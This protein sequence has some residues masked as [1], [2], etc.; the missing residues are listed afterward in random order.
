MVDPLV[1]VMALARV[2]GAVAAPVWA[3]DPWGLYLAPS[4]TASL[5]AVA[6]GVCWLRM[7]GRPPRQLLAGDVVLL[8]TGAGH[9]LAGD[10]DGPVEPFDRVAKDRALAR[11]DILTLG[12][13]PIATRFLCATYSADPHVAHPLLALLPEVLYLAGD[14]ASDS[15]VMTTLRLIT[16]ELRD[17]GP[18]TGAILDRL[19]EVLLIHV[20]RG[21]LAQAPQRQSPSWLLALRDPVAGAA[22]AALHEAPQRPWTV[23]S[24]AAEV[25]VS[26][27][28]L[29][30]RFTERVGVAP[31]EY[32]TSWRM[33]L[34]A[35]RLRGGDAPVAAVARQVGYGS[36]FAFSRAFARARGVP[37]GRYRRQHRDR[38]GLPADRRQ[39]GGAG[40]AQ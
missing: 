2:S 4:T 21:W 23:A 13:G 27:A 39:G 25:G 9:I 11:C 32:L 37:P 17:Q 34:A 7:P 6:A 10:S 1:D 15:P 38:D 26:R 29:A 16:M 3:S 35:A 22:V 40:Q 18:G 8:P 20:V 14:P 5:H 33:E 31:L 19:I 28:T 36:E 12:T 30:R 24:L